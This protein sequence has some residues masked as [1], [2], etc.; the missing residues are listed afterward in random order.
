MGSSIK[1]MSKCK[2]EISN[3]AKQLNN[4]SGKIDDYKTELSR[5]MNG[6]GSSSFWEGQTAY[7]WYKSAIDVLKR[8]CANY[9]NSYMEFAE[10]CQ[11]FDRANAKSKGKYNKSQWK[12]LASKF[13]GSSYTSAVKAKD[14]SSSGNVVVAA[15]VHTDA[16][17]DDQ[18]REAYRQYIKLKNALSELET[19]CVKMESS[20]QSIKS[21]TTGSM[22]TDAAKRVSSINAQKKRIKAA[23]NN[24]EENFIGDI[25]FSK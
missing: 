2:S 1:S 5:M 12:L 10:L 21:N 6:N 14:K 11:I 16:S 24:L 13:D 4:Y 9:K 18:T 8:L 25:L 23:A 15:T 17:N 22:R 7:D 3:L 20:W 19:Y